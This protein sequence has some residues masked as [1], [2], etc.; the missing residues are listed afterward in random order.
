MFYHH[1][2]GNM[3]S[4]L[5]RVATSGM[6]DHFIP[7]KGHSKIEESMFSRVQDTPKE[8]LNELINGIPLST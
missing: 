1:G 3:G 7:S 4:D 8:Y 2:A 5:T 6:C